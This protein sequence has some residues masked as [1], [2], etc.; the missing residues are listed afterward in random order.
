MSYI[1]KI[2]DDFNTW[3][4]GSSLNVYLSWWKQQLKLFVP[5]KYKDSLFIEPQKVYLLAHEEDIQIWFKESDNHEAEPVSSDLEEQEMWWH[6]VQHIINKADG[7][8]VSIEYL[9]PKQKVLVRKVA[10]PMAAKENLDDVIGFELDKY[11]PFKADQVQLSYKINNDIISSEKIMLDLAVVPKQHISSIS[12]LCEENSISLDGIDI[13]ISKTEI[14]KKLGVNLLPKNKRK[15]RDYTNLKVNL[16]LFALLI[17][18]V[19]FVMHTSIVNKQ[20]KIEKLIE[21]NVELQKLAKT[22]KL[23]KKELKEVIVSSKF[24]QNKKEQTASL[25]TLISDLT[26]KLPDHTYVTRLRVTDD[27]LEIGG[28]SDNANSL[29]PK[30]DESKNWFS[31]QFKGPIRPDAR[32]GKEIFT[33]EAALQEAVEGEE[34]GKS[35]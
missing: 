9:L 1:E 23:L 7:K 6:L 14:P 31:P 29:I 3:Y 8:P 5:E 4:E 11:V 32:T 16:V 17:A 15:A 26:E 27:T 19:Y 30:L 34:N 33:I 13:N 12:N 21:Q 35:S 28:Q 20:N 25:V 18:L 22:S 24:L 10:L 2:Q